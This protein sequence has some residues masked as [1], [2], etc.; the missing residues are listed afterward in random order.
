MQPSNRQIPSFANASTIQEELIISQYGEVLE[1]EFTTPYFLWEGVWITPAFSGVVA[2]SVTRRYALGHR[3]CKER[4]VL[5]SSL[6]HG[7]QCWL[8]DGV[9]GFFRGTISLPSSTPK[10][11]KLY[12]HPQT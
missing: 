8:S 11:N 7:E 9:R 12:T 5:R 10:Q 2:E 4:I 3:L 6:E 1:G